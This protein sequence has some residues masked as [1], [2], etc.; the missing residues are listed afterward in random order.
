MSSRQII[1]SE[2][3]GESFTKIEHS[4]GLTLM[5]C[6]MKGFS[7][8]Y[9]LFATK[10]GSVDTCFKTDKDA[11][12][13]QVPEGIA[14]FLEHKLFESEDGDA[15]SRYAQTGASANAYTSFDRTA[16]LFSCTENF[17]ESIEILLDFVTHPYFTP[18]TVQKE[19]GIIGQEI[20]MYDDSADWRVFFNLLGALYHNH[21]V[22][23]DIAGTVESISHIDADLL[24]RCYH[25]FYNLNNMVLSI[26]GNFDVGT[27]LEAADRILKKAE[28]IRIERK[29][30]PEPA[31]VVKSFVE[32]RLP[33]AVPIFQM[34]FKYESLSASEN[35]RQQVLGEMALDV[36]AGENTPLYR[37]L[38]DAGL[39]NATF[40]AETMV[41]ADY[42]LG[43]FSGESK[44]PQ[45]VYDE[46]CAEI[47]RI[48]QEGIDDSLFEQCKKSTYGRYVG[49]LGRVESVAT[50]M[51]MSHFSGVEMYELTE[52]V[53][54]VTR[55]KLEDYLRQRINTQHSALSVVRSPEAS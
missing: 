10:Y 50:W 14:H 55:E 46:I 4:S 35:M 16:Y 8:A 7:T 18:A 3:L 30:P 45:R 54:N 5:L 44:D 38:Y 41:G 51:M 12:F 23:I 21:P 32:Q 33:V 34:G 40:S 17:K 26:A 15:F 37:R 9:A 53:A 13:A 1:T 24:Y 49:L 52:I 36:V 6:P 47:R 39:I 19:Q 48:Q 22:R 25:T 43:M 31:G 28:P 11:D 27:V 2:R 42:I 20:K 29:S